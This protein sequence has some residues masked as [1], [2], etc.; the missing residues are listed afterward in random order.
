MKP[1]VSLLYCCS[2]HR[3]DKEDSQ[4]WWYG[5]R[6]PTQAQLGRALLRVLP[7]SGGGRGVTRSPR[8]CQC[9]GDIGNHS[10]EDPRVDR[11][12]QHAS[13]T[14]RALNT[15]PGGNDAAAAAAETDRVDPDRRIDEPGQYAAVAHEV[16][17]THAHHH[18]RGRGHD[19]RHQPSPTR[20]PARRAAL[21]VAAVGAR[22]RFLVREAQ[23]A[24]RSRSVLD[25][26]LERARANNAFLVLC[27]RVCIPRARSRQPTTGKRARHVRS[28]Q[29]RRFGGPVLDLAV[30][31]HATLGEEV[32]KEEEGAEHDEHHEVQQHNHEGRDVTHLE[33]RQHFSRQWPSAGCTTASG[34]R[35]PPW[36][37]PARRP[38]GWR[39]W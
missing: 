12:Q 9:G 16:A 6:A 18:A 34:R 37:P 25:S 3:T 39:R 33:S 26:Q 27:K 4:R 22:C 32:V 30:K 8:P 35:R 21:V 11:H 5:A 24:R 10:D 1:A 19:P 20:P 17:R 31:R 2:D 7:V 23:P 36:R 14:V 38:H 28:C 29:G 13:D 15:R